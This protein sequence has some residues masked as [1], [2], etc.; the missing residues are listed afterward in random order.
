MQQTKPRVERRARP[1]GK[2][3]IG[4][5]GA[6]TARAGYNQS[7]AIALRWLPPL[8]AALAL[9]PA[10][11]QSQRAHGPA[12]TR[13]PPSARTQLPGNVHARAPLQRGSVVWLSAGRFVMGADEQDVTYAVRLCLRNFPLHTLTACDPRQFLSEMPARRMWTDAFGIDRYEVTVGDYRRCMQAGQC[14]P[15]SPRATRQAPSP[16]A[17]RVA[18]HRADEPDSARYPQERLPV[19]GLTYAEAEAYCRYARGRLPTEAEWERAARGTTRRHFPWGQRYNPHLANHGRNPAGPYLGDGY[20]G[21]APVGSFPDGQSPHGLLDIAGNVWEW[22]QSQPRPRDLPPGSDV[23]DYR[24]IRGGSFHHPP[25]ALRVTHRR[26]L[27]RGEARADLGLR[28]AYSRPPRTS[29]SRD[30]AENQPGV[31]FFQLA[32]RLPLRDTSAMPPPGC[33]A[34]PV[35]ARALS[36]KVW[37]TPA[38]ATLGRVR[39]S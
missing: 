8:L 26:W 37:R 32:T 36:R 12:D 4:P 39:G 27:H 21:P 25:F 17:T 13:R 3:W 30:P 18:E 7:M 23:R 1:R 24:I 33:R 20:R 29:L 31:K 14:R 16:R 6:V 19:S 9:P 35:R 28:C 22:T 11:V 2:R 34:D 10:A 38:A 5:A 15:R